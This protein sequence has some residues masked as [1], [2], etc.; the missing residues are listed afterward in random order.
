[1]ESF[2]DQLRSLLDVRPVLAE[3]A[4]LHLKAVGDDG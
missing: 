2:R 3:K 1:L 4:P